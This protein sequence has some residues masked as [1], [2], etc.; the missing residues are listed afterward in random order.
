MEKRLALAIALCVGFMLFWGWLFPTP[1]PQPPAADTVPASANGATVAGA[2]PGAAGSDDGTTGGVAAGGTAAG[3]PAITTPAAGAPPPS[4]GAAP[5]AGVSGSRSAILPAAAVGGNADETF[6]VETTVASVRFAARG[7]QVTSWIL[8]E[9]R[10]GAGKPLDIVAPAAAKLGVRP[11]DLAFDDAATTRLFREAV[12]RVEQ[13]RIEGPDGAVTEVALKWSNGAGASAA[14]VLRIPDAGY[15]NDLEVAAEVG[16]RPAGPGLIWGAGFEP[17]GGE[18][19]TTMGIGTRAVVSQAGELE[20]RYEV[21]LKAGESW[22][23]EGALPW[24]GIENKYFAAI[25]A[26]QGQGLTR[27]RAEVQSVIEEGR[28]HRHMVFTVSGPQPFRLFVGPKDLDVLKAAHL[29]L[30]PLLDFGFFG[31]VAKPLFQALRF[32]HGYVGNYGV[33]IIVLTILIRLVFFPFM[34]RSQLKMRVMQE[35]MKRLNPKLKSLK[36]RFQKLERAAV[37]KG[38][39]GARAK[40]RQQMNEEMM[41]LYREEGINPF[42]SMSGCLPLLAQMPIL[43]AFYTILTLAIDLRHAPFMLWVQDL[44]VQDPYYVTPI[45][46]GATMLIQ[47]WMTA[48]MIADPV[49]RRMMYFMPVMFTWFF[50]NL[51]SGLVLYWLVNNLIGILQQYLV[52]KEADARQAAA[53][54]A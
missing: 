8:K 16:G 7:A 10:D 30:E 32:I 33:A 31:F 36:E 6:A 51:P 49:Q 53:S 50:L 19:S 3:G 1:K 48:S 25:F 5:A 15:V 28:E 27:A 42:A 17:E 12:Y 41:A 22:G 35:N 43:Y 29:G 37:Q 11:L 45:L 44:S 38:G 23:R 20:H 18:D 26:P 21:D 14:K 13:R 40:V 9:Y 34:H 4:P 39:A 46:M 2:A 52:N 54:A 47:Q 24:A